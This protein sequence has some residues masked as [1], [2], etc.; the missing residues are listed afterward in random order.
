MLPN[1]CSVQKFSQ[2]DTWQLGIYMQMWYKYFGKSV[3]WDIADLQ[4][5][6]KKKSF[7]KYY[8]FI[9]GKCRCKIQEKFE[10]LWIFSF[11]IGYTEFYFLILS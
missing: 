6:K 2:D 3:L 10:I 9:Y 4:I 8:L 11:G 7:D 5:K 1:E